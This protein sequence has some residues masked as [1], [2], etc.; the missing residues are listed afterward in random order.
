MSLRFSISNKSTDGRRCSEAKIMLA[1]LVTVT[2]SQTKALSKLI[3][4]KVVE[5]M[6]SLARFYLLTKTN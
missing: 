3:T 1:Q 5:F 4:K 6:P 2:L